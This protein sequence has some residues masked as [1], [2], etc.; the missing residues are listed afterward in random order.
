M[1]I[2]MPTHLQKKGH[3]TAIM[4][5]MYFMLFIHLPLHIFSLAAVL[6]SVII[7]NISFYLYTLYCETLYIKGLVLNYCNLL[8]K[9]R[10]R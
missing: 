7:D 2:Y 9:M 10:Y 8:N 4:L 1:C 6:H 5:T 3:F